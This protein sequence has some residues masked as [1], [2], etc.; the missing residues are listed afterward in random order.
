VNQSSKVKIG[1]VRT[2]VPDLDVV[3]GG[4]LPE[5]SFNIIAGEPGSGK[6][7]LAHQI[8]FANASEDSRAIYFTLLGEPPIKMLRYQQQYSFYDTAK[9]GGAIEFVN[10]TQE[11]LENDFSTILD[12]ITH[13]VTAV[14][15]RFVVVDSFRTLI[16]KVATGHTNE[17]ELQDF[18][19]R[20]AIHLTSWQATTF[21]VGEYMSD[22]MRENPVFTIADGLIWLSQSADGNSIVRKLQ[23]VK[24]RGEQPLPGLHTFRITSNGL[25]VFPRTFVVDAP[26]ARPQSN[27]CISSGVAGLDEMLGNGI[28]E[29]D[30]MVVA[31]PSGT[32]KSVFASQFIAEGLRN[33]ESSVIAVFGERPQTF[34]ERSNSLGF[35]FPGYQKQGT[36]KL[37]HLHA[38]DLS[39]DETVREILNAVS[40]IGAK[41]LVIDSL[42]G[43]EMILAPAFRRDFRDSVSRMLLALTSAGV[44]IVATIDPPMLMD[45]LRI[46]TFEFPFLSDNIILQRYIEV[47]GQLKRIL[48]VLKNRWGNH[49][50]DIREYDITERGIEIGERITKYCGFMPDPNRRPRNE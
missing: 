2:G 26:D 49:S 40:A 33:G 15:P 19:Q 32:G 22:E 50:K 39:M 36:L 34:E 31:G 48:T 42:S 12:R 17:L 37:L 24:M 18:M 21:L 27:S 20:L 4:G 14:N 7:T 47:D 28:P 45:D 5:Y 46:M 9:P 44:T 35:G 10:L 13:E 43:L 6:T 11:V 1:L 23:V 8:L 29:G 38:L 41:R 3:L 25:E 16:R 30:I